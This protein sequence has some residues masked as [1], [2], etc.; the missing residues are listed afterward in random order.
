[1]GPSAQSEGVSGSIS[2]TSGKALFPLTT[3]VT[4]PAL[5]S[6]SR[7]P[8]ELKCLLWLFCFSP[9]PHVSSDSGALWCLLTNQ[10]VLQAVGGGEGNVQ[11]PWG[12]CAL[13]GEVPA[14]SE[15]PAW[16]EG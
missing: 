1:M 6:V 7:G 14:H 2:P 8:H 16:Q 3:S 13:L 11:S 10:L 12:A 9:R 4:I 15:T 5:S